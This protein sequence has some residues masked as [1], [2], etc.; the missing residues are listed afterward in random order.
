MSDVRFNMRISFEV[1]LFHFGCVD[2]CLFLSDKVMC[3]TC[4]DDCLFA[5]QDPADVASV[6]HELR[7]KCKMHLEEE[8]DVSGFLGVKIEK[9]NDMIRLTQHG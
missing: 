7:N 8:D 2:P 4:V 1:K 9:F 3:V 5:A 6:S